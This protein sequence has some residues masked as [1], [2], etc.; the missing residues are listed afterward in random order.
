MIRYSEFD[1]TLFSRKIGK[2]SI[3]GLDSASLATLR[4]EAAA[5]RYAVVFVKDEAFN[6]EGAH[7][8]D[9]RGLELM[10]I[11]IVLSRESK[12]EGV[13]VESDFSVDSIVRSDDIPILREAL[14]QVADR[15]RFHRAFGQAAARSLYDTWLTNSVK[16]AAADMVFVARDPVAG[17]PA[18][19]I[20]VK[21][22]DDE[23]EMV[24]VAVHDLFRA[25]GVGRS[26]VGKVCEALQARQVRT[27]RVGTQLS[28]RD[29]L[30]FYNSTGFRFDSTVTDFHLSC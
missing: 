27:C 25:S 17:A 2:A 1:S 12:P 19:V 28:N 26:L 3:R 30:R 23:A 20:T 15:S 18:G 10:D 22:S 21:L 7:L 29:A 4:E 9:W 13:P 16:G 14:W 5:G 8:L 11:K 6:F 24:L